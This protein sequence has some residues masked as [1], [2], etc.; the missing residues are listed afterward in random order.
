[1][2]DEFIAT[3]GRVLKGFKTGNLSFVVFDKDFQSR[4]CTRITLVSQLDEGLYAGE[5]MARVSGVN[6]F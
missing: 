5:P 6:L 1:V 2:L 4:P 3:E